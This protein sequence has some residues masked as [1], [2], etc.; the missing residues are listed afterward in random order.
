MTMQQISREGRFGIDRLETREVQA[1][2][3]FGALA[4]LSVV[5]QPFTPA[6]LVGRMTATLSQGTLTITGDSTVHGLLIEQ[7]GKHK[8]QLTGENYVNGVENVVNGRTSVIFDGVT[9]DFVLQF[10]AETDA[11]GFKG[12]DGSHPLKAPRDVFFSSNGGYDVIDMRDVKVE[13]DLHVTMGDTYGLADLFRAT[14]GRDAFI[15]T[16]ANHDV[17]DLFKVE[18]QRNLTIAA[19]GGDDALF[20]NQSTV[21]GS[22]SIQAGDGDDYVSLIQ[23][24]F[25]KDLNLTTGAGKDQ[26]FLNATK[27]DSYFVALGD[28]DD[29]LQL[30]SIRGKKGTF[31]GGA[32]TDSLKGSKSYQLS[33]TPT[34][35]SFESQSV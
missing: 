8:F 31:D 13:R 24:K 22:A 26:V 15:Q 35:L 14:I 18:V 11:V 4:D 6:P 17:I 32:G 5:D 2:N 29:Q 20:L 25:Q 28:G 19:G 7:I 21:Q 3:V 27:A 33:K 1:G 30:T 9:K 34:F 12:K 16:G 10:G 23:T